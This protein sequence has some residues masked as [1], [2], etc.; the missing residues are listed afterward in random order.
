MN[1]DAYWETFLKLY[2]TERYNQLITIPDYQKAR[3]GIY[4]AK[5]T[6]SKKQEKIVILPSKREVIESIDSVIRN[7]KALFNSLVEKETELLTLDSLIKIESLILYKRDSSL[8]TKQLILENLEKDLRNN[9]RIMEDIKIKAEKREISID[10][11]VTLDAIW[12]Y[13]KKGY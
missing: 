7:D 6:D 13:N 2:P 4:V 8:Y 10:S 1:K 3:Q 12:L 5:K 11:M 9:K